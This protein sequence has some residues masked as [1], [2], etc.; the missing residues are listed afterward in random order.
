VLRRRR[1]QTAPDVTGIEFG[2]RT[3]AAIQIWTTSIDAKAGVALVVEVAV[4][5]AAV[6]ERLGRDGQ[7]SS[8]T[9]L[10][11][12]TTVVALILLAAGALAALLVVRPRLARRATRGAASTGLIYFGHL[13]HRTPGDV[14]R[15]LAALSPAEERRQLARQLVVTS[16]VAWRKHALLQ[17]SI[18]SFI[19]GT[20]LLLV[21]LLAW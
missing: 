4:N 19:A 16:Q 15:A 3:H 9:G 8:A 11:L 17:A 7:L 5:A 18:V 6:S 12:A 2:W 13:R 14:E 20:S 21:A 10:Q 1:Q